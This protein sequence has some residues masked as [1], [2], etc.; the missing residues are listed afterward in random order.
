MINEEQEFL[1]RELTNKNCINLF[2]MLNLERLLI[3]KCT[4]NIIINYNVFFMHDYL[5]TN[6]FYF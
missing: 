3:I 6:G 1:L 2:L 5:L 4:H